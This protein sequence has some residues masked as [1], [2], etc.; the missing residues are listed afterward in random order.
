MYKYYKKTLTKT[1]NYTVRS[2]IIN[3]AKFN[4]KTDFMLT[5]R[6]YIYFSFAEY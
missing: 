3:T 4:S 1:N 6:H 2:F 5:L